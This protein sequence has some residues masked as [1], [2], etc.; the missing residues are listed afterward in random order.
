MRS[1]RVMKFVHSRLGF[2]AYHH[3]LDEACYL[4]TVVMVRSVHC[5]KLIHARDYYVTIDLQASSPLTI[6]DDLLG[7][8]VDVKVSEAESTLKTIR[9]VRLIFDRR[10]GHL[11]KLVL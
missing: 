2:D 5:G 6:S 9:L 4:I 7:E 3:V 1:V 10:E 11:R 8:I